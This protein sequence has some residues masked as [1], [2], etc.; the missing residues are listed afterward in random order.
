MFKYGIEL[1]LH[2]WR[3]RERERDKISSHT[4]LFFMIWWSRFGK[5]VEIQFDKSG[6]I[7]G[8][9]IRTYLLERSRVCQINSPERNYHCFYFLCAAPL[10]VNFLS[11]YDWLVVSPVLLL[12]YIPYWQDIKRYKL[13]DPSSFHY[14]NQSTCIKLD[15]ISDAKEY[16]ATRSAM[17]TV[18]ITEQEQVSDM[19]F[20][21][22]YM[23]RMCI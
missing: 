16:L 2:S 21:T 1:N 9:A 18:G 11:Q 4:C 13:A 23:T 3:E 7:S 17:N 5:F 10:E 14:L 19:N 8:A 6:K 22:K 20:S 15:E 12:M